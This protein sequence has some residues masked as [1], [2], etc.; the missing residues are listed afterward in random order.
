MT[1]PDCRSMSILQAK[2]L[3]LH[4]VYI[5]CTTLQLHYVYFTIA[6]CQVGLCLYYSSI[7][8]VLYATFYVCNVAILYTQYHSFYAHI[9]VEYVMFQA[10]IVGMDIFTDKKHEEI[11][12]SSHNITVPIVS[13]KEY[14]VLWN[15]YFSVL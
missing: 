15:A 1:C 3:Q 14:Q 10:H 7:V 6:F 8:F 4:C 5:T 13:R 12:P 11:C 9:T 2:T